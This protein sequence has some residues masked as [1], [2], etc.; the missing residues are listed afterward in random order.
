MSLNFVTKTGVTT[1]RDKKGVLLWCSGLRIWCCHCSGLG[2]CCGAGSISGPGT[3]ICHRHGLY[4]Y[5][6]IYREREGER[7]MRRHEKLHREV[8]FVSDILSLKFKGLELRKESWTHYYTLETPSQRWKC[9]PLEKT[10]L[11][12][13]QHSMR[14]LLRTDLG[15]EDTTKEKH[16]KKKKIRDKGDPSIFK[17]R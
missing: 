11:R 4:I 9:K 15:T 6:Y 5:I 17:R 3:S 1:F 16:V 12:Q 13:E 10:N 7:E 8:Y 14:R 2:C